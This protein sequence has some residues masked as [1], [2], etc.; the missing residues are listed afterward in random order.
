MFLESIVFEKGNDMRKTYK[1]ALVREDPYG[2]LIAGVIAQAVKD[3]K[4]GEPVKAADALFWLLTAGP[5]FALST[6]AEIPPD[7]F[8]DRV[9][10]C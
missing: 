2:A 6:G 1:S 7:V 9:M 10:R 4:S 5:D 3:Y 8:I